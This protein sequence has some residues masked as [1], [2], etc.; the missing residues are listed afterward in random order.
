[1]VKTQIN[2]NFFT[3]NIKFFFLIQ[4]SWIQILCLFRLKETWHFYKFCHQ[5][6]K[7]LTSPFLDHNNWCWI[8]DAHVILCSD[9]KTVVL[10][11]VQIGDIEVGMGY[12][13]GQCH[14]IGARQFLDLQA[15]GDRRIVSDPWR[16]LHWTPLQFQGVWSQFKHIGLLVGHPWGTC[17]VMY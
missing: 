1:M 15:V 10:V 7:S 5:K 11:W 4:P 16:Q 6:K 14:P 12:S 2:D 9:P 8:T 13:L 3:Q 17:K